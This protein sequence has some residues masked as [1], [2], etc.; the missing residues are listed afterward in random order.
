[1][2]AAA[3]GTGSECRCELNNRLRIGRISF[4]STLYLS[5]LLIIL[6]LLTIAPIDSSQNLE[7][8]R[9]VNADA[10]ASEFTLFELIF[11]H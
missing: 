10:Y 6:Y 11:S 4:E 5:W 8:L 7:N 2:D 1:V 3:F 9:D